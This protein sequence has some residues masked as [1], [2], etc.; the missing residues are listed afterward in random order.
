MSEK[1][2]YLY[3]GECGIVISPICIEGALRKAGIPFEKVGSY[4]EAQRKVKQSHQKTGSPKK[5]HVRT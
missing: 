1:H 5:V 2:A 3:N 4:S